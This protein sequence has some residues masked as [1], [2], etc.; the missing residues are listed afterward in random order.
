MPE[1]GEEVTYAR[2]MPLYVEVL[3][4]IVERGYNYAEIVLG[5]RRRAQEAHV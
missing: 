2:F 3:S 4:T 1:I 5:T